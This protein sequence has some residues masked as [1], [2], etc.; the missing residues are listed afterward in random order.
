MTKVPMKHA[1]RRHGLESAVP[2][3]AL[4]WGQNRTGPWMHNNESSVMSKQH[5]ATLGPSGYPT[6]ASVLE[7]S[8]ERGQASPGRRQDVEMQSEI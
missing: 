4:G 6:E 3:Q 7:C 8:A 1:A 5:E 2:A